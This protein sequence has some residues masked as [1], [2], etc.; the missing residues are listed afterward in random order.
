MTLA[1]RC[2]TLFDGTGAD[3]VRGVTLVIEN[4]WIRDVV[5]GPPPAGAEVWDLGDRFVMPGL[6]DAHTH[7][8]IVPARGDQMG[9]LR[10]R[11]GRKALRVARNLARDL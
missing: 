6:I 9:Q 4:G 7:L 5:A 1:L 3:P 10:E 11:P 2:G 8:S